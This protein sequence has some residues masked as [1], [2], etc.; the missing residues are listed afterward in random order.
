[1]AFSGGVDLDRSARRFQVLVYR[2]AWEEGFELNTRKSRFMR[3]GIR[4]Q[5]AG[6]VVNQRMNIARVEFD[7]LRAILNK[8]VRYGPASQNRDGRKDFKAYLAGRI[9]YVAMLNAGRGL[10]LRAEFKRVAW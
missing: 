4:Q 3:Q 8:C 5:L 6:I 1:L 9:A 7:R 2:I 10:R